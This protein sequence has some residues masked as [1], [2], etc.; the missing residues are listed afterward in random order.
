MNNATKLLFLDYWA[1]KVDPNYEYAVIQYEKDKDGYFIVE[2]TLPYYDKIITNKSKKLIVALLDVVNKSYQVINKL[3]DDNPHLRI[4]NKYVDGHWD[5]VMDKDGEG[6]SVVQ[7]D[8]YQEET[9]EI[10]KSLSKALSDHAEAILHLIS[11]YIGNTDLAY[12]HI[13]DKRLFG[14]DNKE[15]I[16]NVGLLMGKLHKEHAYNSKIFI[17]G[18]SVI[19]FGFKLDIR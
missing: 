6:Y 18:N 11:R 12:F 5:I 10:I 16:K 14:N 9:D 2:A 7:S 4:E 8:K 19:S 13:F 17:S 15:I 1:S 3:M